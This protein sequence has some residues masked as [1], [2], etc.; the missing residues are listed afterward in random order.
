VLPGPNVTTG[1]VSGSFDA[2][3]VFEAFIKLNRPALAALKRHRREARL[4]TRIRAVDLV[5][6]V[7]DIDRRT[8][9]FRTG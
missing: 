8:F 3:Q 2:N 4:R 9:R 7:E 6:G 1:P 5:S